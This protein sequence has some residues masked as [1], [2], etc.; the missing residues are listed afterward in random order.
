MSGKPYYPNNWKKYKDAPDGVFYCP[1][2]DEFHDWKLAGWE[3]PDSVVCIIRAEEKGKIKEYTY[4]KKHAAEQRVANLLDQGV[5]FTVVD[6]ESIH[7]I[8]TYDDFDD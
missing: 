4:Q 2:F 7:H 8:S 5:S 1:T 3:L 6:C